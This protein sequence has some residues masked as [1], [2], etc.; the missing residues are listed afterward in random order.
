MFV[1]LRRMNSLLKMGFLK[2]HSLMD[3]K[4][5]LGFMQLGSQG[6]VYLGRL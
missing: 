6:G 4:A 5:M 2:I 3:G 1:V